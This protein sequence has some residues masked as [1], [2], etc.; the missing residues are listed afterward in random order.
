MISPKLLQ[1]S[2]NVLNVSLFM[3][4]TKPISIKGCPYKTCP[5]CL[6][7]VKYLYHSKPHMFTT[8]NGVI[9]TY[10]CYYGCRN[11][12][13]FY[14]D[15]PYVFPYKEFG[16]DIYAKNLLKR[17]DF[18]FF[19]FIIQLIESIEILYSELCFFLIIIIYKRN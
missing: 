15:N 12:Q 18:F 1:C 2:I 11:G 14:N 17:K 10:I 6:E 7:Q 13:I 5:I 16:K 3:T 9:N 19:K 8:L 4:E